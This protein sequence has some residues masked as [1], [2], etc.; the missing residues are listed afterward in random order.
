MINADQRDSRR[1]PDLVP[2]ALAAVAALPFDLPFERTVGDEIQALTGDPRALVAA[3]LALTRVGEWHIGIGLGAVDEPLPSTT[4]EARGPAYLIAR[5][6]VDEARHAPA[7]IRLLGPETVGG[8][9]YGE[10][11]ERAEA[12]LVMVRT[13][14]GRRTEQGWEVNDVLDE[15]TTGQAA[16]RRLGISPSAVSQRATRAARAEGLLGQKLAEA[17]VAEAMR[18]AS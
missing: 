15:V 10:R 11:I 3:V 6:A 8:D 12:A 2:R 7:S 13:V 1:N 14:I 4:R 9:P 17:L 16:A 5:R 18:A